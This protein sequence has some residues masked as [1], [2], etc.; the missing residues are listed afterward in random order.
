MMEDIANTDNLFGYIHAN[1]GSVAKVGT[2][3][4]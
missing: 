4:R 3:C 1:N 2:M